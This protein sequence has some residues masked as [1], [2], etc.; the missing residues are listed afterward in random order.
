MTY[1]TIEV[2]VWQESPE[3]VMEMHKV[4]KNVSPFGNRNGNEP[5]HRASATEYFRAVGKM[6]REAKA[7]AKAYRNTK[8]GARATYAEAKE[9][10]DKVGKM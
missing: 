9:R 6:Q 1:K 5:A 4:T 8:A 2:P 10:V 3:G 7:E